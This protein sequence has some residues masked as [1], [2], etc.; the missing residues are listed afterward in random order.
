MAAVPVRWEVAARRGVPQHRR[1]GHRGRRRPT[2]RHSVHVDADGPRARP[3]VLVPLHAPA[4]RRARSAARAPRPRADAHARAPALRLRLLPAVRAGLLRRLPPHGRRRRSTWSPSSAT[5]STSRPGAA[6]TCARTS[7]PRAVHAR[8]LPHPLRA[9]QARPG[10][11][12]RARRLPVDRH[13][14]RPRGRQR[15]RGRPRRGRHRARARSSRAAPRPTRPTTSTCRCAGAHARRRPGACA[16]TPRCDLGTL[17][18]FSRAR[19]PPVP[20]ASRPARARARGGR[21][22]GG[23]RRTAPR[24]RDPARTHAR[25]ARRSAGSTAALGASRARWNVLAQQT[26]MAQFDQQPRRRAA[27]LDRRLGRLSRGAPAAARRHLPSAR[28]ANPVVLGGDVHTFYVDRPEAR[29]RRPGL[30]G[31]RERVRRHLD[32]LAGLAAGAAERSSCPTI[33]T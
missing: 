24:S 18:R 32:H 9:L 17:A 2:G 29:F 8:R 28:V 16:S 11:A 20:L 23:R 12:G 14:G 4:T 31:R 33:R 3:L 6:T 1:L 13:L 25:R 26:P 30:A 22:V 10:P 15:L 7:A 27:R 5:T 19:R 21:N